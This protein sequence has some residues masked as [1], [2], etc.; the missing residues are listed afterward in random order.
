M[1]AIL[2][3][4]A[5]GIAGVI[6][7]SIVREYKPEFTME[8]IICT[9]IILLLYVLESLKI[10]FT[11][12]ENLYSQISCGK[13]YFPIVLKVLAIA[14]ATE[15]TSSLCEDANE[16]SIATKIELAGK[17]AIFFVSLPIFT[18]LINLLDSIM[19]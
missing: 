7:I 13:E 10:G 16:K 8:V 6:I 2:K 1:I 12:I 11:F 9:S 5:V 17:M 19:E 18:S 4:C 14:Y 15:F 3:I